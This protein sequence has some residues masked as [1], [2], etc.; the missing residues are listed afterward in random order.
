MAET[1]RI[2]IDDPDVDMD[3]GQRLLYRGTLFTGEAAEYFGEQIVALDEYVDGVLNG[4]ASAWY[5]DGALRSEGHNQD[6][7][8][9]GE[10]K[11]WHPNGVLQERKVFDGSLASLAEED[12]WDENG[13]LLTSWRRG[14]A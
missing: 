9:M 2:D 11:V 4:R 3:A 14:D 10:F 1:K 12:T 8:P 5:P 13:N 7:R 6:G